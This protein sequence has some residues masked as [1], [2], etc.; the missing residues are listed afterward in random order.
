MPDAPKA[1]VSPKSPREQAVA[2]W[3]DAVTDAE[4]RAVVLKYKNVKG[5]DLR[6]LYTQAA[7][8]KLD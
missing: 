2:E 8:L 4:K 1:D 6:E 7:A 3:H 5:A